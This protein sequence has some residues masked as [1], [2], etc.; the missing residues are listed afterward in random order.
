MFCN[1]VP[2]FRATEESYTLG[3]VLGL[4]RPLGPETQMVAK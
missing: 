1:P 2:N 4:D 3:L